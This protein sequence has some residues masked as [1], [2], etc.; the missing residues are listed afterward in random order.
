MGEAVSKGNPS[1]VTRL[2]HSGPAKDAVIRHGLCSSFLTHLPRQS[3]SSRTI[4]VLRMGFTDAF[5]ILW[6]FKIFSNYFAAN[7]HYLCNIR[8]CFVFERTEWVSFSN[9][10]RNIKNQNVEKF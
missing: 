5:H 7:I 6:A 1:S 4:Q 2:G 9:Q 3:Q 10:G 8:F